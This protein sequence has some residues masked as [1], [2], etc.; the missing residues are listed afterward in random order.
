MMI[1]V[2]FLEEKLQARGFGGGYGSEEKGI[3]GMM[4]R[5]DF[6]GWFGT[7]KGNIG[8][9]L[10]ERANTGSGGG[11][12][13]DNDDLDTLFTE[14]LNDLASNLEKFSRSLVAVGVVRVVAEIE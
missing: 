7:N 13:G 3:F 12:A 5:G 14:F 8:E 1:E 9:K 10:A 2:V 11:V 6:D 4:V